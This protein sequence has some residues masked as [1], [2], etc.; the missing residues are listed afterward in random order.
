MFE[1]IVKPEERTQLA[2]SEKQEWEKSTAMYFSVHFFT[3]S[4]FTD[5]IFLL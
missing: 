4:S 2:P 5:S 1:L 3:Q